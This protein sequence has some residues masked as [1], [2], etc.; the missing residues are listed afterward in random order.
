MKHKCSHFIMTTLVVMMPFLLFATTSQA[1]EEDVPPYPDSVAL[2]MYQLN[3]DGSRTTNLCYSGSLNYG[4]TAYCRD[5]GFEVC[6][7]GHSGVVYPYSSSS[8][9]IPIETYYLLNVISTEMNPMIYG[10][11]IA[12]HAQ[13]IAARSFLGWYLNNAPEYYNNSNDRQVFVPFKFDS[14]KPESNPMEPFISEPCASNSLNNAQQKV[15]T[16]TNSHYYIAREYDNPANLPAFSEFTADVFAQ[17]RDHPE[18]YRFSY[19]LGVDDPISTACDANDFGYNLA[20]MSQEGANRWARGHECS[21]PSAPIE[22]GNDPG[23]YW[24][25][26][27]NTVEQIL[28]H[29]YT[30]VHLRDESGNLLSA[31]YRWNPLQVTGLPMIPGSGSTYNVYVQVQNVGTAEYECEFPYVNYSLKYRWNKTGQSEYIGTNVINLCDLVEGESYGETISLQVPS[32]GS[33]TY[34]LDFDVF[35]YTPYS[36]YSSFWFSDYDWPSYNLRLCVNHPCQTNIP[37]VSR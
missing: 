31:S 6:E 1:A 32:W 30:G 33:G 3:P 23:D 35:A 5:Y 21:S 8:I 12:L 25:V 7:Y 9:N 34:S 19:L 16:A 27:W 2:T 24:S 26:Q 20:G 11:P 14:L 17:T 4:C 36:S 15:C 28:F 10:E 13:T 22:P 29:Y 18:L 37:I